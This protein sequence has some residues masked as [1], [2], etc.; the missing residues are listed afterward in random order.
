M[1]TLLKKFKENLYFHVSLFNPGDGP[2]TKEQV[3]TQIIN[4]GGMVFCPNV[5]Q[6]LLKKKKKHSPGPE[7]AS[8]G[9]QEGTAGLNQL[10][11]TQK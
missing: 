4:Q 9:P 7:M 5:E 6:N 3:F 10:L 2:M 1:N 8:Q 11:E